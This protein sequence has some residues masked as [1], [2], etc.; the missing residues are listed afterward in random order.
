MATRVGFCMQQT[1]HEYVDSQPTA[2]AESLLAGADIALG[3]GCANGTTDCD[4]MG[5]Y[6]SPS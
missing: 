3:G 2:A 5:T 6:S 4:S 1:D